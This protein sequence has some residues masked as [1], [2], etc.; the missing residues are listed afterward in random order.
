MI[1]TDCY[2]LR[3][4]AILKH[5]KS[6]HF[7][8]KNGYFSVF[9]GSQVQKSSC[10]PACIGFIDLLTLVSSYIGIIQMML[11][12][13]ASDSLRHHIADGPPLCRKSP[14]PMG[15]QGIVWGFQTG[16]PR[17]GIPLLQALNLLLQFRLIHIIPHSHQKSR[18][19]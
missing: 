11:F 15:G 9:C 18:L 8:T 14:D 1:P 7:S 12:N 3:A 10:K 19:I 5:L 16:D 6:A 13:V 17:L 2:A 4:P